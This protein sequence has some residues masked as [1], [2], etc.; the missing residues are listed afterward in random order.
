MPAVRRTPLVEL[1]WR[2]HR[3]IYRITGGRV[4]ARVGPL[5]VLLLTVRG[6]RSGEARTVALNYLQDGDRHVVLASHAGEDRDPPWWLNLRA[7]GAGDIQIGS[8]RMHMRAREA[9]GD[10]RERLWS[11]AKRRD[12]AYATYESRTSRRIPVVVLEPS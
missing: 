4:G 3:S 10:E 5:P 8:R 9:D 1:G 6:R 12:P 2:V 7:A 11:E